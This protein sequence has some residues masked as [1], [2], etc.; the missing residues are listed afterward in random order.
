MLFRSAS[1]CILIGSSLEDVLTK[2]LPSKVQMDKRIFSFLFF[3]AFDSRSLL[4]VVKF[5]LM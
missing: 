2:I 1:D 3:K 5:L 4:N